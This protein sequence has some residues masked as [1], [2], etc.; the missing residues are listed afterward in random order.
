MKYQALEQ[1]LL[2]LQGKKVNL[3]EIKSRIYSQL[4]TGSCSTA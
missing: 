2:M 4:A 3:K 1:L